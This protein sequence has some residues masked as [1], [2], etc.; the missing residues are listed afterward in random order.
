[1]TSSVQVI[2]EE[3]ATGQ[4]GQEPPRRRRRGWGRFA[5][6]Y[7]E[8]TVAMLAGMAVL[9]GALR[10]VLALAGVPYSMDR[11]P[12]LVTLEMGV[13][14][15]A[16]MAVWMRVRRH[17]WA[18]TLEMSLAMLAPAVAVG[19]LIRSGVGAGALDHMTAM[20]VEHTTMFLLMF[21]VMLR[22]REEYLSHHA[23]N[24]GRLGRAMRKA[25]RKAL[26]VVGRGVVV[27]LAF[28]AIPSVVF[29]VGSKAYGLSRY[30]PPP[31]S[32]AAAVAAVAPPAYDASKP[33]AVVVVGNDGANVAD[34]LVPYDVLASTGAFNVYTVAQ[35][36]RPVPL[37]G[38]LDLVPDFSFAQLGRLLDGSAPDVTVVPDMPVSEESDAEVAAW[39]RN[40]ADDGLLLGVCTGAR[41]LAEAGLLDGREATSHWYRLAKLQHD[42]PAVKWQRGLR[43]I[44]DGDV[45]TTGGLL[46]SVDGTLRVV[47]R[48]LGTD[49]A[50]KAAAAA[51]W[52]Y[53]SPGR[54][55]TMPQSHLT[56]ANAVTHVLNVGFRANHTTVG[57]VLANGVDELELAAAF[58]PYAEGKTARTLALT[59]DGGAIRSRHGLTFVPRADQGA[60]DTVDRV[61]VTG[62]GRASGVAAAAGRA[63]VPVTY[64][65]ERN[66]FEFDPAIEEIARTMDV[67]TARWTAKVLEYPASGLDSSGPDWP[68]LLALRPLGLGLLGLLSLALAVGLTRVLRRNRVTSA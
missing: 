34:T 5:L 21:A 37:L 60:V 13:T 8:M 67:P 54:A 68:W 30:A 22:R 56:P 42:H 16:G 62:T 63:D 44:D 51:G 3:W 9:G 18:P 65:H 25:L 17:G 40:T 59:A 39:L 50:A 28:L 33:T 45:I 32:S 19:A 43:Y 66:G 10:G 38:G 14:M 46:S 15:A 7:L 48:Q 52:R 58:D 4:T 61:L 29:A 26:P 2:H 20:T 47:E 36:R 41:L 1:M 57:V 11:H 49:T 6:H 23:H 12:V 55:A 53:Y 31:S 35:D 64:L 27:L 24:S